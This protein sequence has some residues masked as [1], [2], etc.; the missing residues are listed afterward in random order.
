M[1]K[2]E[3]LTALWCGSDFSN[4]LCRQFRFHSAFDDFVFH[5]VSVAALDEV[6]GVDAWRIVAGV[7]DETVIHRSD[8]VLVDDLGDTHITL[9]LPAAPDQSVPSLIAF[10]RPVEA[11]ICE[12]VRE[13]AENS[14]GDG[15]SSFVDD[16]SVHIFPGA[17]AFLV[18]R[19]VSETPVVAAWPFASGVVAGARDVFNSSPHCAS[20]AE[21]VTHGLAAA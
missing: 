11:V 17:S 6:L 19:A 10:T 14:V 13:F 21:G 4:L 9:A 16:G 20:V 5:V 8:E 2:S 1:F 7:H 15:S 3:R 18:G 12:G